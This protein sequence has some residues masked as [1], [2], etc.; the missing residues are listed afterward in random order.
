MVIKGATNLLKKD[1][2]GASD[3]YVII[4]KEQYCTLF[5]TSVPFNF[6]QAKEIARTAIISRTLNPHWNESFDSLVK[7]LCL[8]FLTRTE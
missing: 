2:F 3:P 4:Y 6:V 1:I 8:R 5:H 7:F